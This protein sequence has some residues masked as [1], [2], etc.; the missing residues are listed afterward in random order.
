MK[1]ILQRKSTKKCKCDKSTTKKLKQSLHF[2]LAD[3]TDLKKIM[4][5]YQD[6]IKNVFVTWDKYYPSRNLIKEDILNK[7]L[8]VLKNNN[9][10]LGVS[11]LGKTTT[12]EQWTIQLTSPLSIG[13]ICIR[14]SYQG[15]GLGS[16]FLNHLIE[17]AKSL[18]AD[19][20]HF[21]VCTQ[22]SSAMRMYEKCGFK[23]CGLGKSNYGFD[24]YKYEQ[25]FE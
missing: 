18:G 4:A 17:K 5:L 2:A 20:M 6:V 16:I 14:P 8:Y 23:N 19:G 10:L 22:N 12:T 9:E 1:F 15:L 21:H 25:K 3:L 13:R 7:T 11:F 24:Y